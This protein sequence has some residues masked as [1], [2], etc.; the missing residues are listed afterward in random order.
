MW[1]VQVTNSS[2]AGLAFSDMWERKK[3]G[4][5]LYLQIFLLY[6][7][8]S[9]ALF[10]VV[11]SLS[12]LSWCL[13]KKSHQF[14]KQPGQCFCK[15]SS[16]EA[17]DFTGDEHSSQNKPSQVFVPV[18]KTLSNSTPWAIN[19]ESMCA[20]SSFCYLTFSK[21]LAIVCGHQSSCTVLVKESGCSLVLRLL[22]CCACLCGSS[23]T[24]AGV[25]LLITMWITSL[26]LK[27]SQCVEN[28]SCYERVTAL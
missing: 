25:L 15:V 10:Q 4:V 5:W 11:V 16:F 14:T 20:L 23:V 24:V 17:A 13:K 22:D 8:W 26:P 27:K 9:K 18:K 1:N 6:F 21:L 12:R 19:P 3:I 2:P 28:L 7:V